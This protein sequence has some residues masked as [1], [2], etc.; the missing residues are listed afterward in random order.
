MSEWYVSLFG[1][2][3]IVYA[4]KLVTCTLFKIFYPYKLAVPKNLHQLAGANWAVITGSTDGIGK[5]YAFELAKRGFNLVLVSRNDEKLKATAKE[6]SYPVEVKTIAF[7]FTN[8]DVT[9][10]EDKLI[11]HLQGIEI[12]IL[13][14]NVGCSYDY[15]ERLDLVAGGLPRLRDVCITN[16]LP[17]VLLSAFVL[18]QMA[19][20][21]S[22][23]LIIIASAAAFQHVYNWGAYSASK[24]FVVWL[25]QILCKEYMGTG[26]TI[27]TVC[28]M[29][30]ATKMSRLRQSLMVPSAEVFARDA[31]NTVGHISETSGYFWHEVQISYLFGLA[32]NFIFDLFAKRNAEMTKKKALR[33]LKEVEKLD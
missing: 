23:I 28:P 26:V 30:V 3:G 29:M 1:L 32:P 8:T 27:Q 14:N 12:G 2:A 7:D 5:A 18:K 22:G 15:P 9:I 13:V 10:Y 21:K 31:L 33:K 19:E 24:K 17:I 6:I 16:T 25:S 20:R 11:K 4:L